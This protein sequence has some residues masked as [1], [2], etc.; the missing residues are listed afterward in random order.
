MV[1]VPYNVSVSGQVFT[2]TGY[3]Q[4]AV[5][6]GGSADA[7]L[8]LRD[9]TSASGPVIARLGAKAG[10]SRDLT[11]V[12]IPFTSGIFAEVTGA[13]AAAVVYV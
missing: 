1:T 5:L 11:C 10:D 12:R 8:I 9:G 3:L 7:V 2:G 13:G 6:V 4:G